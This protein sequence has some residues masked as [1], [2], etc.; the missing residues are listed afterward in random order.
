MKKILIL[1][2][3]LSINFLSHGQRKK[4]L[5]K[6]IRAYKMGIVSNVSYDNTYSEVWN[7]IYIIATEEYNTIVR[8]SESRGFIEAKQDSDTFKE[9]MTI[10]ILGDEGSYRVSFQV[11]Q[12]KRTKNVDGTYSNWTNHNS[13]TLRSYYSRLRMRLYEQL[14]GPLELP[15]Q[16]VAKIEAYN[17]KQSKDR[18]KIIY[19][20]DY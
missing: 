4:D 14:K 8:E 5:I 18:K 12:E 15:K 3:V 9:S 20:R 11:K 19:G 1:I 7:A 6:E 17:S 13:S 2:T 16:L 10:E